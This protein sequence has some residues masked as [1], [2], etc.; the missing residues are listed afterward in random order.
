MVWVA[1][2]RPGTDVGGVH[3]QMSRP[4]PLNERAK[5]IINPSAGDRKYVCGNGSN[6]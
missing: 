4:L 5:C 6:T 2:G 1:S 3:V